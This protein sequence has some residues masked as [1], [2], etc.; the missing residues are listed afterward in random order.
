LDTIV[1]KTNY[2][3]NEAEKKYWLDLSQEIFMNTKGPKN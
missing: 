2:V 3:K 1:N